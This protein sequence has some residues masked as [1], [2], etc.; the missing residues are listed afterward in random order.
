MAQSQFMMLRSAMGVKKRNPGLVLTGKWWM[1]QYIRAHNL[2][3]RENIHQVHPIPRPRVKNPIFGPR[4]A[5]VA[6]IAEE[7][8]DWNQMTKDQVMNALVA[9]AKKR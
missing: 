2:V 8:L 1:R 3:R 5:K 7:V 6:Q 4:K 9:L